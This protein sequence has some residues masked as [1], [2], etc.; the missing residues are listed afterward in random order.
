MSASV[1][2]VWGSNPKP[3]ISPTRYHRLATAAT[4]VCGPWPWRKVAELGTTHS[5][6]PK[7]Y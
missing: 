2:E 6:H 3:I 7:G 1:R 5:W 4:F